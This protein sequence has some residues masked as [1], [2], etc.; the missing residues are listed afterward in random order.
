MKKKRA[1]LEKKRKTRPWRWDEN[2]GKPPSNDLVE[3]LQDQMEAILKTDIYEQFWDTKKFKEQLDVIEKFKRGL[4]N[5]IDEKLIIENFDVIVR[6]MTIKF[7][8]KNPQVLLKTIELLDMILMSY[9]DQGLKLTEYETNSFLQ[10]ILN[11][12]V[13]PKEALARPIADMITNR[14]SKIFPVSKIVP[15]LYP[16]GYKSKNARQ[17]LECIKSISILLNNAEGWKEVFGPDPKHFKATIKE[18]ANLIGTDNDRPTK[19]QILDLL[20]SIGKFI[21]KTKLEDYVGDMGGDK[22]KSMLMERIKHAPFNLDTPK[23]N[24][25]PGPKIMKPVQIREHQHENSKNPES[26]ALNKGVESNSSGT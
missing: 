23:K 17:R 11:Q 20:V 22:N 18:L 4:A 8:E 2:P 25:G 15:Y 14:I 7:Y 19:S 13:N 9:Q 26:L 24:S 6:W 12:I 16:G 21:G 3:Q 10:H 5:E 1:E